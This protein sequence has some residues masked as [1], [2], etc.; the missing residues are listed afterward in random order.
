MEDEELDAAMAKLKGEFPEFCIAELSEPRLEAER[1]LRRPPLSLAPP[2]RRASS[3]QVDIETE[4]LVLRHYLEK[5]ARS[6]HQRD[7]M[8]RRVAPHVW[9]HESAL[10][11]TD[12][13]DN[14]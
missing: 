8:R 11:L 6:P 13:Y 4:A 14:L 3:N 5:L 2:D 10:I 12:T 1:R 9:E 7:L